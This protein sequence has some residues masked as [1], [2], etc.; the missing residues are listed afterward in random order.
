MAHYLR[1]PSGR[2]L[3]GVKIAE[4][5]VGRMRTVD[6]EGNRLPLAEGVFVKPVPLV[7]HDSC[8]RDELG[9]ELHPWSPGREAFGE[10]AGQP[11]CWSPIY[12]ND[13]D[14]APPCFFCGDPVLGEG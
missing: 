3:G 14:T 7:M 6:A 2:G 8:T 1:A 10:L 11:L 5:E 4:G 9:P 12:S 13:P